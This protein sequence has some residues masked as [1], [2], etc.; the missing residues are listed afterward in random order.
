[1]SERANIILECPDFDA[2]YEH[3]RSETVLVFRKGEGP[4]NHFPAATFEYDRSLPGF[5]PVGGEISDAETFK[6]NDILDATR[7]DARS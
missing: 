1:M 3:E 4:P 2:Y 7:E 6:L 5:V